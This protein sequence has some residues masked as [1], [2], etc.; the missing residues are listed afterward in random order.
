M[1]TLAGR[2][3]NGL[4]FFGPV[5][6]NLEFI[7]GELVERHIRADPEFGD[8]LRLHI[9][10]ELIPGRYGPVVDR[11]GRVWH[12]AGVID[13]SGDPCPGTVGTGTLRVEC[14]FFGF[15][16]IEVV[17][18]IRTGNGL[19][20]RHVD[21]R[22]G[23]GTAAWAPMFGEPRENESQDVQQFGRRAKSGTDAR[24]PGALSQCQGW[25]DMTD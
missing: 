9:E 1:H 13:L 19:F 4:L 11:F 2:E 3:G 6:Y 22:L 16:C 12:Q 20:E 23:I 8:D 5:V 21:G 14:Q 15:R 18:T 17:A 25:R 7:V 10:P 24:S